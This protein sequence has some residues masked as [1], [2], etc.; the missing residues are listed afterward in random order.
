GR[1]VFAKPR[2]KPKPGP[3]PVPDEPPIYDYSGLID[4]FTSPGGEPMPGTL[5][6]Q[7]QGD[8]AFDIARWTLQNAGIPNTAANRI[9]LLRLIECSPYN[10]AVYGVK[11]SENAF[12]QRFRSDQ[13]YGIS[14][15]PQ[16]H[17]NLMRMKQGLPVRRAAQRNSM[18]GH[19]TVPGGGRH[20]AMWIP[21]L[22]QGIEVV[23]PSAVLAWQDG[24]SGINPPPEILDLGIENVPPGEYGCA[25]WR[26]TLEGI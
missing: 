3:A 1:Q 26:T 4:E 25:P 7:R 14:G 8:M 11:L 2:T 9:A 20:A 18:S 6:Y 16:H 19:E 21:L 13:P 5:Y 23:G 22:A 15:N 10:D 12:K 17:D 24:T